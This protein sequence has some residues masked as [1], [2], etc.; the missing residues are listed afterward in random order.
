MAEK[1]FKSKCVKGTV[2]YFDIWAK[3]LRL[4]FP[5]HHF[6]VKII[7]EKTRIRIKMKRIHFHFEE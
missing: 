2:H 3:S 6:I 7:Q 5:E 4:W 1:S